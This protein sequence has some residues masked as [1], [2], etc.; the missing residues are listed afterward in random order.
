MKLIWLMLLK[1]SSQKLLLK[2]KI[3]TIDN[4]RLINE[5]KENELK[6]TYEIMMTK[7]LAFFVMTKNLAL[8]V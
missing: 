5:P 8:T 3:D 2:E 6:E 4:F 7:N 1:P